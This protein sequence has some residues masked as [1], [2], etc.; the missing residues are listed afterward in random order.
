MD[1][2]KT[3]CMKSLDGSGLGNFL[4][5]G[6]VF[7]DQTFFGNVSQQYRKETQCTRS[8]GP[9]HS[10]LLRK[11][12]LFQGLSSRLENA[13]FSITT[14]S[15]VKAN[16][17]STTQGRKKTGLIYSVSGP[18]RRTILKGSNDAS[19]SDAMLRG[20]STRKQKSKM[21]LWIAVPVWENG[22]LHP[23]L[24]DVESPFQDT[25][26]CILQDQWICSE[27]FV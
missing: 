21:R 24:L 11:R 10:T 6:D 8:L 18:V 25:C 26:K 22:L 23:N 3:A 19:G 15:T 1:K 2:N 4:E 17:G 20:T 5:G 9:A 14:C 12:F 7:P 27:V 16:I 13:S